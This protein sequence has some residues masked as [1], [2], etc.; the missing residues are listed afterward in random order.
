[1][2]LV[3]DKAKLIK[4]PIEAAFFLWVNLAYL[5][6]FE[7]G[8]KRTTRLSANIPLMLSNCAP[9]SFL[10]VETPDYAYAMMGVYERCNVALAVDLFESAYRRSVK[11]YAILLDAM[12]IPDPV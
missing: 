6:P 4:N 10:S 2:G 9:L 1:L 7:D 12:G 8:N 5:Q 3:V 11:R